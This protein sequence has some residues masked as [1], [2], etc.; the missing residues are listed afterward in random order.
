M[1]LVDGRQCCVVGQVDEERFVAVNCGAIQET[2]FEREFFGHRKGSFTGAVSDKIG[3]VQSADGGTLFLDEIADLPLS[4][5]VKLLRVLQEGQFERLG[6]SKTIH[7]DVRLITATNR[8]LERRIEENQFRKDLYFR[9]NILPLF[10][11]PLIE[12][13]DDIPLLVEH[14]LSERGVAGLSAGGGC[15]AGFN[16]RNLCRR[17]GVC[18]YTPLVRYTFLP[19]NR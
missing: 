14:F 17:S 10:I 19:E 3:L 15:A 6:S 8:D 16:D 18:R 1:Q 4:M 5:Q 11:P 2:L 7:V 13:L 12:R 9:I